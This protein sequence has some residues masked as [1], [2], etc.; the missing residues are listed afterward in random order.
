MKT[1]TIR[2]A[3]LTVSACALAACSTTKPDEALRM[4]TPEHYGA[5]PARSQL[6]GADGVQQQ[7]DCGARPVPNGGRP[8]APGSWMP[9]SRKASRTV[10]PWLRRKAR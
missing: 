9:W 5:V 1:T 4:P 6:P 2:L 7:L 8:M 3:V 10:L